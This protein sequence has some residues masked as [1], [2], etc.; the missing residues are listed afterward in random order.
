MLNYLI[1]TAQ[2][3]DT[4]LETHYNL[5]QIETEESTEADLDNINQKYFI[6]VTM[7]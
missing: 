3:L 2:D 7:I 4:L 6:N 5:L 1:I